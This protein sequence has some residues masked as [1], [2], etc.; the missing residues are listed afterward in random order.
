MVT[1]TRRNVLKSG[2]ATYGIPGVNGLL[3]I[4]HQLFAEGVTPP[5]TLEVNFDGFVQPDA[6]AREKAEKAAAKRA[7]RAA[8]IEERAAKALERAN[9]AKERADKLAAQAAKVKGVKP[10]ADAPQAETADAT[11]L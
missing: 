5:E 3:V 10:E 9:K 11:E 7:E 1:L 8:K 6:E 4:R 2:G